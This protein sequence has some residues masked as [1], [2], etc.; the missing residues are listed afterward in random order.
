M[1]VVQIQVRSDNIINLV[2]FS[3]HADTTTESTRAYHDVVTLHLRLLLRQLFKLHLQTTT[4]FRHER[5]SQ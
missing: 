1:T 4:T 3:Y 2:Q 5:K